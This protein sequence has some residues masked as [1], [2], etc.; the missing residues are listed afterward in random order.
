MSLYLDANATEP[1]RPEARAAA[2]AAMDLLGNPS[3]VHAEGRA[4][5]RVL[6][7]ARAKV[8]A[9]FGAAPREVVFTSGGTEASA[10]AITALRRG[11]RLLVGATE[12]PA[13]MRAAEGAQILPVRRDGTLDLPSLEAALAAGPPALVCLM[14]AN[15]E[16]GV[17]HPVAKAATLCHRHGALLHLDGV[18]AAGRIALSLHDL[19]ADTLAISGHKLGGP[20]GAGALLLRAGLDLTPLIPGGGQERGRRGGTEAL[21]AIAGLG[22]AAEAADPL[23]AARLAPLRDAIETRLGLPVAGVGAPR[24][25]NTS[26][27]IL[28]GAA[29]ETQVI[30]LDLAGI[31]VSAGAACSS[32]RV[33][34]SPVLDAMGLGEAAGHAI[35]VSLPW[36]APPDTVD[37]F[38]A[39]HGAMRARLSRP[40]A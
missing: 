26:C 14:V 3:S 9:R 32:G 24:L 1:L 30:A 4:A 10:L 19:G 16:T 15:N 40:A 33:A 34:R 21:P 8:A 2:L 37:R 25:P 36:N 18:Q 39:A 13:V 27:L 7:E 38:L 31:R 22:A 28:P 23:G 17:I 12:H 35:R 6:E 29:A 5:R 11:R 20:K